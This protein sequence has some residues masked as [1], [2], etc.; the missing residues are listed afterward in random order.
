MEH[1]YEMSPA[2][3]S[4]QAIGAAKMQ[5][6]IQIMRLHSKMVFSEK[7]GKWDFPIVFTDIS[8]PNPRTI[9]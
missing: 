9:G 8:D 4:R 1:V 2:K 3:T 7:K 6:T 5:Q